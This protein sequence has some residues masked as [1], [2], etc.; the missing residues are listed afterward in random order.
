MGGANGLAQCA[1][2]AR[3][4]ARAPTAPVPRRRQQQ[5]MHSL[6]AIPLPFPQLQAPLPGRYKLGACRNLQ[7]VLLTG[8]PA[9]RVRVKVWPVGH[10]RQHRHGHPAAVDL[11]GKSQPAQQR[12]E[13]PSARGRRCTGSACPQPVWCCLQPR[14]PDQSVPIPG[15]WCPST[16][17]SIVN[18]LKVAGCLPSS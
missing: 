2:H 11:R 12:F 5:P 7:G 6:F 17:P 10:A 8:Q 9:L 1:G 18:K 15:L 16:L 13:R 14:Q 4:R 3:R